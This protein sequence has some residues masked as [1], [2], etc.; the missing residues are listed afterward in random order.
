MLIEGQ[1]NFGSVDGD[2]PAAM[3][4][5]E[6]RM[7]KIASSLLIDLDKETVDFS[8]NYDETEAIPDVLPTRVPNLLING[9]S[10]IAVGMAT[11]I[12]PHNLK[13]VIDAIIGLIQ[14]PNLTIIDLMKYIPGPDFPTY[15]YINGKKGILDAYKTGRGRIIMRA[16]A[17][18]K[19]DKKTDKEQIIITEIPYQVNKAKLIEKIAELVKEKK[20]EGIAELRDE[21]DKD[22]MRIVIDVKRSD[23]SEILLNNLYAQ[24]QLQASFGVNMVALV[25]NQ[26]KLLNLKQVLEAFIRHRKEIVIRRTIHELRKARERMHI[27]E[28]LAVALY[29][30]DEMILIIKS[31]K[32]S[33]DAKGK[34]LKKSWD[35]KLVHQMT[36]NVDI[37]I[38]MPEKIND[39]DGL[40]G[41]IYNLSQEQ[42]E[43]ILEL[44]LNRLTN[45][46]VN[47]IINEFKNLIINISE[48]IHILKNNKKL[49]KVIC[50]ELIEI[51]E[52]FGDKRRSEIVESQLD[53]NYED[54]IIEENRVVTLSY[55]GYV[56][57][58]YPIYL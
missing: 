8:P 13:E 27:L 28:G 30:I 39:H 34:L 53:L 4:Y 2:S 37:K 36:V 11:N 33:V 19:A 55:D 40:C 32:T 26:P 45:L 42:V 46:E 9:S 10:G 16:K 15:A 31:S 50:R 1:G 17:I 18:I 48:L 54:L 29:N 14:N 3:R 20:V 56:I 38:Y 21:S 12:P 47:K 41:K 52:K 23:I 6:V 35:G 49:L 58:I 57:S 22:G 51:K 44:K 5:T 24:T 43:S 25:D 7:S